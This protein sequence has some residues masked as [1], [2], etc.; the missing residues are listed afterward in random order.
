MTSSAREYIGRMKAVD[1][2]ALIPIGVLLL[3]YILYMPEDPKPFFELVWYQQATAIIA[4]PT[5]F[6]CIYW[7]LKANGKWDR[8]SPEE[9]VLDEE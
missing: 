7:F 2:T 4:T 3:A 5:I 1:W 9:R 6:G 8:P